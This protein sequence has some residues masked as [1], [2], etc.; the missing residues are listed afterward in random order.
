MNLLADRVGR[1]QQADGVARPCRRLAHLLLRIVEAH[2]ARADGGQPRLRHRERLAVQRVEALRDVARQFQVLRLIVAHRHDVGLIQQNVGG[3]QHRDT[4]AGRR[5]SVSCACDLALYCVIRSSQP[6]GVTQVSIQASSACSAT[7]DC[8]TSEECLGSMPMRQQHPGQLLN[9][10]AQLL[11]I[12]I[13]RDRMQVDDA[14][15]AIVVILDL[16]P[17]LQRPQIISDVRAAG[18]LNAG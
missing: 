12:L 6:T 15:D 9:L 5:R 13:N 7:D 14:V 11:G 4:A 16:D 17:V 10:G 18:R 2:D 8:T 1:V 3:H